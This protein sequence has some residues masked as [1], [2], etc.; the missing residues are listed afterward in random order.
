MEL[1]VSSGYPSPYGSVNDELQASKGGSWFPTNPDF[2]ATAR[3]SGGA[4]TAASFD[5][6]LAIL[7]KRKADSISE[8]GLIGHASPQTFSLAGRLTGKNIRF[9]TDGILHPDTIKDKMS[10][11]AA[12]KDRFKKGGSITLFA[13]SA[14]AGPDLMKELSLAFEIEIRGF[15]SEIFWCFTPSKKGGATRGRTWYDAV[16]MGVHPDCQSAHF[17]SDI[18]KWG[19]DQ[20]STAGVKTKP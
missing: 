4:E 1:I 6:F 16:G 17:E 18:R 2:E 20:S 3:G 5:Q 14:G 19:S 7:S 12:V 10:K 9:T 13:C 15:K 8:L 11:I